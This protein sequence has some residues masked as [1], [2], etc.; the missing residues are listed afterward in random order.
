MLDVALKGWPGLFRPCLRPA[1][2]PRLLRAHQR[3]HRRAMLRAIASDIASALNFL[4]EPPKQ[5][6]VE[7]NAEGCRGSRACGKAL[8][9]L[10]FFFSALLIVCVVLITQGE[11]LDFPNKR[12]VESKNT[13]DDRGGDPPSPSTVLGLFEEFE[14]G[15]ISLLSCPCDSPTQRLGDILTPLGGSNSKQIDFAF[16]PIASFG[17]ST[18]FAGYNTAIEKFFDESRNDL[19][20][21]LASIDATRFRA[22][23]G[24]ALS[25]ADLLASKDPPESVI[26]Q[27]LAPLLNQPGI[28][29]N[30]QRAYVLATYFPNYAASHKSTMLDALASTSPNAAFA[31]LAKSVCEFA[32]GI[33]G[34]PYPKQKWAT[35]TCAP[36]GYGGVPLVP[37]RLA[38]AVVEAS[39]AYNF[40]YLQ[41]QRKSKF[42]L[43]MSGV[44]SSLRQFAT[45]FRDTA[46]S[47]VFVTQS[48][49]SKRELE[50]LVKDAISQ[51]LESAGSRGDV[52]VPGSISG[53]STLFETDRMFHSAAPLPFT[54]FI[55][56]A[57]ILTP[58][59]FPPLSPSL[60]HSY[61]RLCK[62]C[63]GAS[64]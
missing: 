30:E 27:Y 22:E 37:G 55:C 33:G 2:R 42:G 44:I 12:K 57:I 47:A 7:E 39:G 11:I 17:I 38:G 13:M 40:A 3:L 52:L 25:K 16:D 1:L 10:Q 46:P 45:Q 62:V 26:A 24:S 63:I 14:A 53:E 56:E 31:S 60:A 61:Q 48:A 51:Q 34:A 4:P 6:S 8:T 32:F 23:L 15:D 41:A 58:P 49:V 21:C 29:L 64:C 59:F 9:L 54:L 5:V 50:Q 20:E 35:R 43:E 18:S 19:S 28:D 36:S